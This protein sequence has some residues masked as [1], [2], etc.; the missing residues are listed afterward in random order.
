MLGEVWYELMASEYFGYI[1]LNLNNSNIFGTME[2]C[3]RYMGSSSHYGLIA[4]GQG[5][6]G[7]N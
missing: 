5:A 3:S 2:I 1:Q 7:D 4:P 6:N